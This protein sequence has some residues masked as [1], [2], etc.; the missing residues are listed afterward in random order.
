MALRLAGFDRVTVTMPWLRSTCTWPISG[1]ILSR[2]ASTRFARHRRS[3]ADYVM[4]A[5]ALVVCVA[6]VIWA[7][8]G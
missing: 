3:P 8:A 2:W 5:A 1:T 6:L 4:V 7:F